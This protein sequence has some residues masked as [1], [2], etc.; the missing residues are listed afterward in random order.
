MNNLRKCALI[1]D[2]VSIWCNKLKLSFG[3]VGRN[4]LMAGPAKM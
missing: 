2:K 4:P 3:G 1:E